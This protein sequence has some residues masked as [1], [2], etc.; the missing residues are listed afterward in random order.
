M[1]RGHKDTEA[2]IK[3]MEKKINAEYSKAEKEIE[4]QLQD[5]FRRYEIKDKKWRE[6]VEDGK[7]TEAEYKAWKTQ[8]LAV[9]QKWQDQKDMIAKELQNSNEIAKGIVNNYTPKIYADNHNYAT[10][11][12]EHDAKINT[13]YTLYSKDSVNRLLKDDPDLLPAPSKKTLKRLAAQKQELWDKKQLQ[14]VMMQGILQGDSIPKL[15]TRLAETVGESDRKAAVRNARTMATGAQNAGRVDAYKRAE[16]L[17][18]DLE[19]MWIATMD[20]RTRHSHRELDGETRPVGEAFSNGCEYP[21]DPNGD[22][23]EVYNCRCTLRGVVKGLERRS[24][25]FRDDSAV[26][27]MSYEE[28]L[29]AKPKSNPILLPEEKG[30]AIRRSYIREYGGFGGGTSKAT[31]SSP[32]IAKEESEAHK[33]LM[34]RIEHWEEVEGEIGYNEVKEL[35]KTLTEKEIIERI[36]GGD[37]TEGSCSSL[38]FA[39]IANK[40]GLDVRDF[41]GGLSQDF[42]ATRFNIDELLKLDGVSNQTFYLKKET[43]DLPKKLNELNLEYGKEYRLSCGKHAAII[44]NTENGYEYLELQSQT[45]SGWHLFTVKDTYKATADENGIHLIK[46]QENCSMSETLSKRFGCRKTASNTPILGE[47]GKVVVDKDGRMI[48]G[49]RVDITDIESFKNNDEFKHIMGYINT[50]ESKQKK[51][52]KGGEK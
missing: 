17:G 24:G 33:T 6:W 22:P 43:M 39:Y 31:D 42:F 51:G 16:D 49:Q 19:Q 32:V 47:D 26:G 29:E 50:D 8:Q 38:T 46:T 35:D 3:E 13:G 48:F 2:L 40:Q 27:G 52:A 1:D 37:M 41:R 44:R 36:S 4:A 25:Q 14:S 30:E 45:N 12:I 10:Y 20:D 34:K 28:W 9:G 5:Y 15:A 18:V 23:S 21:A 7:K 11:Q